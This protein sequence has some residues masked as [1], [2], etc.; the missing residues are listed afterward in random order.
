LAGLIVV[1]ECVDVG[2]GARCEFA[3][4]SRFNFGALQDS[5]QAQTNNHINQSIKN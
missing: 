3:S 2:E 1:L 4:D 5:D